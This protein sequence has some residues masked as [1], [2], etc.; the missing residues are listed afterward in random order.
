MIN[1]DFDKV[2]AVRKRSSLKQAS[3]FPEGMSYQDYMMQKSKT[4]KWDAQVEADT[5][6]SSAT[7]SKDNSSTQIQEVITT[8][9]KFLIF[10]KKLSSKIRKFIKKFSQ[11]KQVHLK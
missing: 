1:V 9:R 6:E 3:L 5:Q 8:V 7:E 4:L 10:R 2:A 11:M